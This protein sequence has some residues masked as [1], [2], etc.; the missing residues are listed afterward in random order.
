MLT[1]ITYNN[2]NN[3]DELIINYNLLKKILFMNHAQPMTN[4]FPQSHIFTGEV[5][6]DLSQYLPLQRLFF[7]F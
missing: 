7:L 3:Q 6:R 2:V 4:S 1:Y 5:H